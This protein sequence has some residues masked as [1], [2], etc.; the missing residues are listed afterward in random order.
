MN[1]GEKRVIEMKVSGILFVSSFFFFGV[2]MALSEEDVIYI[3]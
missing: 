2:Q 1:E 3:W